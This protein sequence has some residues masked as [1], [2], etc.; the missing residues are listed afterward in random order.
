MPP[1]L[2]NDLVSGG[3]RNQMGKPLRRN[4]VAIPD[5][6]FHRLGEREKTRHANFAR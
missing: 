3:V 1:L 5:G 2:A 4:D 6:L